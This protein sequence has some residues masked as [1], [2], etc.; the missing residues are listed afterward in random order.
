[1][2]RRLRGEESPRGHI[3]VKLSPCLEMAG[4]DVVIMHA[5]AAWCASARG[6]TSVVDRS[7][8]DGLDHARSIGIGRVPYAADH[9]SCGNT[10]L[11]LMSDLVDSMVFRCSAPNACGGGYSPLAVE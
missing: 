4:V 6:R 10:G 3:K 8:G 2:W 9:E 7:G 1:M 11:V 5:A